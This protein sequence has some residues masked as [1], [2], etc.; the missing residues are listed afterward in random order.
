MSDVIGDSITTH[1][2]FPQGKSWGTSCYALP[3]QNRSALYL[4]IEADVEASIDSYLRVYISITGWIYGTHVYG[5][6]FPSKLY[7]SPSYF[8]I[9][10]STDGSLEV[11]EGYAYPATSED[12]DFTIEKDYGPSDINYGIDLLS[13]DVGSV[14][15]FYI[16]SNTGDSSYLYLAA[17]AFR[18]TVTDPVTVPAVKIVLPEFRR[19]IDYFPGEIA[20]SSSNPWS[21]AVSCTR[22]G[23][24]FKR[25]QSGSW[26]DRKNKPSDPSSSTVFIYTNSSNKIVAPKLGGLE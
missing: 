18:Y 13:I 17:S 14:D 6:S 15:D 22:S 26:L 21:S 1:I 19:L 16:D 10:T 9:T 24:Y 7:A 3:G 25:L 2:S 8:E 23:G 12:A 20:R 5:S 4:G 11:T